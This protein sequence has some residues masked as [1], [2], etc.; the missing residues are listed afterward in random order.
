MDRT[1]TRHTALSDMRRATERR[2]SERLRADLSVSG[3]GYP[4]TEA[5]DVTVQMKNVASV[6]YILGHSERE[7][8]RLMQQAAILRPITE[9]LMRDA[10]IGRGMRVL[11][12]GCG[13]G[14]VSMLAA[15]L[16]GGPGSVVGID[17][18]SAAIN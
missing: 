5:R 4:L 8:R 1:A 3:R 9:R 6:P 16:V 15:E 17:R 10:G 11:D 2:Q 12:M 13:V 18:S 7:I 14:D